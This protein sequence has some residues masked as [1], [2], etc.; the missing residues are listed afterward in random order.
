VAILFPQGCGCNFE[1]FRGRIA[2]IRAAGSISLNVLASIV[3]LFLQVKHL[4]HASRFPD[5]AKRIFER[6][7]PVTIKLIFDSDEDLQSIRVRIG[8]SGVD[9]PLSGGG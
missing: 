9:A 2:T 3:F 8:C 4:P 1:L 6:P 5:V 7:R